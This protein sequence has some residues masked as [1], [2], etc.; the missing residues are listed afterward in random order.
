VVAPL[1]TSISGLCTP[2]CGRVIG[3]ITPSPTM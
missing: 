3:P 2:A 1:A